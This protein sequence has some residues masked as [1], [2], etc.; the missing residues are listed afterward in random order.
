MHS[1]RAAKCTFHSVKLQKCL[2]DKKIN[3]CLK[4]LTA[5]VKQVDQCRKK[6]Q[7]VDVNACHDHKFLVHPRTVTNHLRTCNTNGKKIYFKKHDFIQ[8]ENIS[9]KVGKRYF[10][11]HTQLIESH[12]RYFSVCM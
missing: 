1:I 10:I 2:M 12:K 7:L 4:L 6:V 8:R 5:F 9:K 11:M 3:A